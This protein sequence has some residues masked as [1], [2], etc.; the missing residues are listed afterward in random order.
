MARSA[1]RRSGR[2]VSAHQGE[3]GGAVIEGGRGPALSG[4]AIC[5][6]GGR[7]G[8]SGGGMHRIVGLLPSGEVAAGIAAIGRRNLQIVV[9]IDVA[10]GAGHVG[11]AIG[12][13][14]SGGAM[15]EGSGGPS[16]GGVAVGA[17]GD[18]ENRTSAGVRRIGGL[19]P[20]GKMAILA[21]AGS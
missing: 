9:V 19:L 8:R 4:M 12:E 1:R 14:K 6:V 5:A 7:E 3:P 10:S 21:S 16:H 17:V 11:M 15:V 13:K 18:G 20:I 2:H